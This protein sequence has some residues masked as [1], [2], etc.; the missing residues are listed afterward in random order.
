MVTPHWRIS[1]EEELAIKQKLCN[2]VVD[3]FLSKIGSKTNKEGKKFCVDDIIASVSMFFA[4]L[5][6]SFLILLQ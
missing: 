5:I 2:D 6:Q 1:Y 3:G 4:I